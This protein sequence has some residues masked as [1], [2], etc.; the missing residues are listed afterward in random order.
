MERSRR[1]LRAIH[2]KQYTPRKAYPSKLSRSMASISAIMSWW[3]RSAST[4][5]AKSTSSLSPRGH[6]E[7]RHRPGPDRQPDRPGARS[8]DPPALR[9]RRRQG[10]LQ[11]DPKDLRSHG[12]DPALPSPQGPQA[13]HLRSHR[14]SA[15]KST[16][17]AT[18]PNACPSTSRPASRRRCARPG[19]W[20]MRKRPS[21]SSAISPGAWRRTR[22]GS[23]ARSS[24]AWTRSSP[25]PVS[26]CPLNSDARS[27]APTSSRTHWAPSAWSSATSSA[28][29]TPK[30][31]CAG[32]LLGSWK[33]KRPSAASKPTDS[34]RS[35]ER[36]CK[37]MPKRPSQTAC[38][39]PSRR[40]HSVIN[41]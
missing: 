31:P 38:L 36:P 28:G 34:C 23:R 2:G 12:P 32:P 27:P 3:R 33:P 15:A 1:G 19:S 4:A 14:S 11:G 6:G 17:A 26:A 40:P 9:R 37:S 20:T 30:W 21:V 16:R 8:R 13:I 22:P 29:V 18:S 24:R 25:S 10:A 7:Q 41:Q 35:S 39:K 5:R